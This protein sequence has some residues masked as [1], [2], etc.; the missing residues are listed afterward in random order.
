MVAPAAPSGNE[1]TLEAAGGAARAG[2]P[3]ARSPGIGWGAG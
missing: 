2:G 1:A 3:P